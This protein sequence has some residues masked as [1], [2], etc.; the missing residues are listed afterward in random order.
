LIFSL[1]LA[2]WSFFRESEKMPNDFKDY[3]KKKGSFRM[4]KETFSIEKY[5]FTLGLGRNGKRLRRWGERQS[6]KQSPG[7]SPL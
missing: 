7:R 6:A 1:T 2:C 4:R 3:L 5:L